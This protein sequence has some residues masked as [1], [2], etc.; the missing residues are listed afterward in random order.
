MYKLTESNNISHE[1][2][3]L[4]VH[5]PEMTF[6]FFFIIIINK[7]VVFFF[8]AEYERWIFGFRL[9]GWHN[10]EK[11]RR[12]KRCVCSP[13]RSPTTHRGSVFCPLFFT[14]WTENL[15]GNFLFSNIVNSSLITHNI[16]R[17]RGRPVTELSYII[18][19]EMQLY[20]TTHVRHRVCI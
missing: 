19:I 6:F 8:W 15:R 13:L 1:K 4:F 2:I 14:C 10:R 5:W 11:N 3:S 7:A 20:C 17:L 12:K 18:I 9:G 16:K